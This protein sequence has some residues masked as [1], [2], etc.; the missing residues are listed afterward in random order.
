[1][2]R[3]ESIMTPS[4][5]VVAA[6]A[7]ILNA[8][9]ASTD[10]VEV[11]ECAFVDGKIKYR[12]LGDRPEP[13]NEATIYR[14]V[15]SRDFSEDEVINTQHSSWGT[16]EFRVAM[17]TNGRLYRAF[18]DDDSEIPYI[19][20]QEELKRRAVDYPA[21]WEFQTTDAQLGSALHLNGDRLLS[22][23]DNGEKALRGWV[24]MSE[25]GDN[26][27]ELTAMPNYNKHLNEYLALVADDPYAVPFDLY[28]GNNIKA[29]MRD[30][31]LDRMVRSEGISR[32]QALVNDFLDHPAET[33][34][35]AL[36]YRE[37]QA[38][39]EELASI[40]DYLLAFKRRYIDSLAR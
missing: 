30:Q 13:V 31:R 21:V 27:Y 10:A 4:Q 23:G 18:Y 1:M 2:P 33:A 40:A 11:S 37:G 16:T 22:E 15:S 35:R 5:E 25:D 28:R 6:T 36:D 39:G 32:R 7:E 20:G 8:F 38:Y 3:H 26:D 19:E 9:P 12:V 24:C 14:W 34:R 17:W 29:A